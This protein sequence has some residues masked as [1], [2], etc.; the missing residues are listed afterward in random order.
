MTAIS[1]VRS[2]QAA[3]LAP[4]SPTLRE[5]AKGAA[6]T[7]LQN[8]LRG[9]G[10]SVSADGQ[11]G[12]KTE[13]AVKSFQASRGLAA[14]GVVGPKTWAALRSAPAA[15]AAGGQPTLKL[16]AKGAAVTQLQQALRNKGISVSVDGDF[17]PKTQAAVKSF[18]A[19]RGLAA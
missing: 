18:Q 6:V 7:Q 13:A 14:D 3:S 19:S 9:K 4:S 17:G 15:P 12:P 10:F 2:T 1:G 16:G 8:L 5:G 11:F